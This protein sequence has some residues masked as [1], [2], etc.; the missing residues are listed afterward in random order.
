VANNFHPESSQ[1]AAAALFWNDPG[2]T[3]QPPG[4]WLQIADNAAAGQGFDLLRHAQ[5]DALVGEALDDAGIAAWAVKYADLLWRPITAIRDC[6]DWNS[7]ITAWAACDATWASLINTPPH[8]DYLAGHPAFSGA[9]ATV[10]AS[11]FGTDNIPFDS[12]SNAYC[13]SGATTADQYGNAIGCTLNGVFYSVSTP[14]A[15]GCNNAPTEYGGFAVTDPN[16][17]ASPLICPITEVFSSFS[18]ASSGFLGAEFSRVVGGIHTP[19]AVENALALGDAIGDALI[20]EPPVLPLL[21]GAMLALG[22]VRHRR[23][24]TRAAA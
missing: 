11:F 2:G 9:A 6:S 20:P 22:L 18:Q 17:N 7:Y 10:L 1:E 12:T 3:F 21:A 16:Y 13:N 5:E 4:H 8:P 24:H 14:G 19:L 23:L 15:L